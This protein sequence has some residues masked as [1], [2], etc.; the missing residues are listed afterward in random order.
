MKPDAIISKGTRTLDSMKRPS[1]AEAD[2]II[3]K[4][5]RAY[6][7]I[8]KLQRDLAKKNIR[9]FG[10]PD[11]LFGTA[12]PSP[13]TGILK[14]LRDE[15]GADEEFHWFEKM[16][17]VSTRREQLQRKLPGF[18]MRWNTTFHFLP[19]I[20]V[21]A[22]PRRYGYKASAKKTLQILGLTP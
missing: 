15:P 8:G 9:E 4:Y 7:K 19:S 22:L 12:L 5:L 6:P 13:W 2:R 11:P 10:H 3:R 1:K 16:P 14:L 18:L 21:T 17:R 20:D